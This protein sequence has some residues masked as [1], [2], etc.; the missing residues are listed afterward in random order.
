MKSVTFH[1]EGLS[2]RTAILVIPA[3]IKSQSEKHV[4]KIQIGLS[5]KIPAVDY[6][7][8]IIIFEMPSLITLLIFYRPLVAVYDISSFTL[9][10]KVLVIGNIIPV[11]HRVFYRKTFVI[12]LGYCLE[13]AVF[14]YLCKPV[15]ICRKDLRDRIDKNFTGFSFCIV[16]ENRLI[17]FATP[18]PSG[19]DR[20][21]IC[22]HQSGLQYAEYD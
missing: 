14:F 2:H 1:I 5:S 8:I 3:V 17:S 9:C 13:T 16:S 4:R 15:I 22:S 18:V 21:V 6:T 20:T 7:C 10:K 19:I 11:T 12:R